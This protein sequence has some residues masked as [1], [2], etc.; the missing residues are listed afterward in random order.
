MMKSTAQTAIGT[1]MATII[2]FEI[3]LFPAKNVTTVVMILKGTGTLSKA[4]E[5]VKKCCFSCLRN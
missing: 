5:Q 1:T 3:S 2:E 4:K